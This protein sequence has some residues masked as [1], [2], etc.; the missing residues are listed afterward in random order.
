M[1]D[2]KVAFTFA[3]YIANRGASDTALAQV[4]EVRAAAKD[5]KEWLAVNEANARKALEKA[6]GRLVV[7]KSLL[8][9]T[10]GG[11]IRITAVAVAA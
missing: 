7:D 2:K 10:K 9:F 1:G 8:E 4:R 5:A 3:D 6:G 11:Q